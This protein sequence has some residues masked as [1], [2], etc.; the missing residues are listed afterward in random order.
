[1]FPHGLNK[2]LY[3]L[4][5]SLLLAVTGQANAASILSM[6]V[7]ADG[8]YTSG[9]NLP[10]TVTFDEVV[11]VSASTDGGFPWLAL[12]LDSGFLAAQYTSGSGSNTLTFTGTL[13][14]KDFD[15][16]GIA[17]DQLEIQDIGSN[18]G[19]IYNGSN[20]DADLTLPAVPDLSLVLVDHGNDV[21]IANPP[22]NDSYD[23]G[24][25]IDIYLRWRRTD[26]LVLQGT[27]DLQITVGS[28]QYQLSGEVFDDALKFSYEVQNGDLDNDGVSLDSLSFN[29]GTL[30]VSSFTSSEDITFSDHPLVV[31]DASFTT[32]SAIKV[33]PIG[34]PLITSITGPSSGSY[35]VGD[36]LSFTVNFNEAVNILSANSQSKLLFLTSEGEVKEATYFS[37]DGSTALVFNYTVQQGDYS[38]GITIKEVS[39]SSSIY[40][41]DVKVSELELN[42]VVDMSGIVLDGSIPAI[43]SVSVPTATTYVIGDTLTFK[44]TFDEIVNVTGIPQLMLNVGGQTIAANYVSGTGTTELVFTYQVVTGVDDT[45]GISI[46]S[47]SLNNASIL[48][49]DG[50]SIDASLVAV[51][52]TTQV[53]VDGG[54]KVLS[55]GVPAA[56]TYSFGDVLEFTVTFDESV[57]VSGIPQLILD[58]GGASVEAAYQSGSN[59]DQL[60][61]QYTVGITDVDTDGITISG[62]RN[63]SSTIRNSNNLN[64][65][66]TLNGVDDSSGVLVDGGAPA[67]Y[68]LAVDQSFIDTSNETSTSITMSNAEVGA[69]YA[70]SISLFNGQVNTTLDFTGTVTSA[71]QQI[72]NLDVSSLNDGE[73]LYS[74]ELT[75]VNGNK[76]RAVSQVVAKSTTTPA[77][78]RVD[79]PS[80]TTYGNTSTLWFSVVTNQSY[81]LTGEPT[82]TI[83]IG[84]T[85]YDAEYQLDDSSSSELVFSYTLTGTESDND[86]IQVISLNLNGGTLQSGFGVDFDLTLNN[87]GV[88]SGV[89][90]DTVLYD[91]FRSATASGSAPMDI[92]DQLVIDLYNSH[93]FINSV[94]TSGGS[95]TL[96][97]ALDSGNVTATYDS[98]ASNYLRFIYTVQ[99]NDFHS[100]DN[101]IDLVELNPNGVV[102]GYSFGSYTLGFS[103]D[104]LDSPSGLDIVAVT[105]EISSVSAVA[106]NYTDGDT[107]NISVLFNKDVTV[108]GSPQLDIE[109]GGVATT[110]TYNAGLTTSDTVVFDYL[111]SGGDEDLDG[112]S[113]TNFDANGATIEDSNN[114]AATLT[115]VNNDTRGALIDA[116]APSGYGMS[117]DQAYINTENELNARFSFSSA[118]VGSDY[119]VNITHNQGGAGSVS[120][121]GTVTDTTQVVSG[122]DVSG[123]D[124]GELLFSVSLTDATGNVG[125]TVTDTV[126]K[127]TV[128]PAVASV[129]ASSDG[130]YILGNTLQA[131]VAFDD[132]VYV[133]GVPQLELIIGSQ[134]VNADYLSGNNT[135]TLTFEV[136]VSAGLLDTDGITIGSLLMDANGI[137]DISGNDVDTNLNNVT[138]TTGI[139]VDGVVPS[140]YLVVFSEATW[141]KEN[142]QSAALSVTSAEVGASYAYSISGSNGGTD[143]TGSGVV[144]SSSFSIAGLDLS[145]FGDG[146]LTASITLTDAPGNQ[147]TSVSATSDK[148]NDAPEFVS[149]PVISGSVVYGET[150]TVLN[151]QTF[152]HDSDQV[153][154]SY[155]WLTDGA[156]IDG[157]TADNL[158]LTQALGGGELTVRLTASDGKDSVDL[159][160]SPAIQVDGVAPSGYQ[161]A[162]SETAWNKVNEQS[163]ALSVTSAEVGAFYAYS[164]SGSNGGTDIIGSG[165]VASSSFVIPSLDLSEFRDGV[166]TASIALT[167]A[168]GNLGAS[169]SATSDK[170]NDAPEFVSE[171]EISGLAVFGE[172]LTVQNVQT[173]DHDND[174]VTVS[175][176]WLAD[177]SDIAGATSDSFVLTQAQ[178]QTEVTVRLTA[179]D[180]SDQVDLVV[181][182]VTGSGSPVFT[183]PADIEVNATGLLTSVTLTGTSGI[184]QFGNSIEVVNTLNQTFFEPGLHRVT[185][186]ATDGLGNVTQQSQTVRVNPLVSFD[187]DR[188]VVEGSAVETTVWLNG[189]APDY[190]LTLDYIVGGTSDASDHNLVSGSITFQSGETESVITFNVT[191]DQLDESDETITLEWADASVNASQFNQQTMT[192]VNRNLPP[193]VTLLSSQNG[194]SG[195]LIGQSSGDVVVS[196]TVFDPNPSDTFTYT[197][198]GPGLVDSDNQT[199]SFT[200]SPAELSEGVYRLGV[201][202]T[203]SGSPSE[204]TQAELILKVVSNLPVLTN[205]DSDG[206]G[207]ADNAEGFGDADQDGIPDYL[208]AI[209]APNVLPL[210]QDNQVSYLAECEPGVS[211]RLGLASSIGTTGGLI[212]DSASI[213]EL[214][215]DI[216][217]EF[218]GAVYDFEITDVEAGDSVSIVL[219]LQ[220]AIPENAVYRKLN[221]NNQWVNFVEDGSNQLASAAGSDGVCPP[222]ASDDWSPG[223]TEGHLCLQLTLEDGGPNDRDGVANGTVIDPGALA[224]QTSSAAGF[225]TRGGGAVNPMFI[226]LTFFALAFA[227]AKSRARK[228]ATVIVASVLALTSNL[229]MADQGTSNESRFNVFSKQDVYFVVGAGWAWN[230]DGN[231]DDLNAVFQERGLNASVSSVENDR[232]A[233]SLGLGVNLSESVAFEVGYL[234]LGEVDVEFVGNT[235]GQDQ[236]FAQ[237]LSDVHPV[238]GKGVTTSL[239]YNW[240]FADRFYAYGRAGVFFWDSDY[241]VSY[242]AGS[243]IGSYSQSGTDMFFGM[244]IG[245]NFNEQWKASAEVQR[246]EFDNDETYHLLAQLNY[247]FLR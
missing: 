127:D 193:E 237:S 232:P 108:S 78:S 159:V 112:I 46:D 238:S 113:V 247:F 87:V 148:V 56:M 64:A 32:Y 26:G 203:D 37:G 84:G 132:Q 94:D 141:N 129:S 222:P 4:G 86:G 101:Q 122:I 76:G 92:G 97:I 150:L 114:N 244:G 196:A 11:F 5:L 147:G 128:R 175:Y 169:V 151:V 171:P 130:M 242:L 219:P 189:L 60:N 43:T 2:Y 24:D 220:L 50:N 223:L 236:A 163:A 126:S 106:G 55:V 75:D 229:L 144:S 91:N 185:W 124:D 116:T 103:I 119:T 204:S 35:S 49:V 21:S 41:V 180:G 216:A 140:G 67:G 19:R 182:G 155:Q 208:D 57:T 36:S 38:N 107:I 33:G 117:I 212:L 61:F 89:L 77:I 164:I 72:T 65:D 25:I 240:Q 115:L 98:F 6:S 40:D 207:I 241:E 167:D 198:D 93:T 154:L 118:E 102:V 197:W 201:Q 17:V 211:C 245:H 172:T 83:D 104:S 177:G 235:G 27:P 131:Q 111:V 99:A 214:G 51:G 100:S 187:Q 139:L 179:S 1:V 28:T 209:D 213:L 176:Q 95:P 199:S 82:L 156:D 110:A 3:T 246:Y 109:V 70:L 8:T 81:Q 202:V 123:I 191:D 217:F 20:I 48:D 145:G 90:V 45:D 13:S 134:T 161:I 88:T 9:D 221:S 59:T 42:G 183:V 125:T 188:F 52:D 178:A 34:A 210:T 85:N 7:P 135:N 22:V 226:L 31:S 227:R 228:I 157:A 68:G 53:L 190:P 66:L 71:S 166:L 80:A 162:F 14:S 39:P 16:D 30:S 69:T 105:P 224:V 120:V 152:D 133:T 165:Q 153:T 74:L 231:K 234:D 146:V 149:T 243:E 18:S 142:E 206:D 44:V 230:E 136:Q 233:G 138:D 192:I 62:L 15:F 173:F 137:E 10:F 47:L 195:L 205:D 181:A 215:E 121:S 73:L 194:V 174:Q 160:V 186:Q 225:E 218:V 58:I 170:V 96:E 79:V 184:D 239:R 200:F 168:T 63:V 54:T 158:V 29:G 23:E 143:L 12:T